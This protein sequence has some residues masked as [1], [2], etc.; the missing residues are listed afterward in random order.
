MQKVGNLDWLLDN[1]NFQNIAAAID[2][3]VIVDA[4]RGLK[5]NTRF[6][7]DL[8]EIRDRLNIPIS[9]GGGISNIDYVAVLFDNG[10]DKIVINSSAFHDQRLLKQIAFSFGRQAIILSIDFKCIGEKV[11]IYSSNGSIKEEISLREHVTQTSGHIGEI[12]FNSIDKDG[13][14][15]GLDIP[16]LKIMCDVSSAPIIAMGGVGNSSHMLEGLHITNCDS[17]CTAN[18][19]NFVGDGL[20][21]ARNN[22]L[23]E[24]INLA[25][26]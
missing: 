16:A 3:L 22:L 23:K 10:A 2:E 5:D 4:S 21:V 11:E 13:T 7:K 9:V 15:F 26:W 19:F 8:N 17:V 14:G 6:L 24:N 25:R 20:L 1:Y 12:L 18:L